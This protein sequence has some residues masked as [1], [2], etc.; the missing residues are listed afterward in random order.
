V[1]IAR[2]HERS[3]ADDGRGHVLFVI[4]VLAHIRRLDGL[5]NEVRQQDE[6]LNPERGVEAAANEQPYS[7]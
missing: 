3:A 4:G 1:R 2:H 6:V 7:G 5:Q